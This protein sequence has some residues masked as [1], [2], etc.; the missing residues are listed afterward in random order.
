MTRNIAIT[1]TKTATKIPIIM[2]K[3]FSTNV[4]SS[5]SD[6]LA[7]ALAAGDDSAFEDDFTKLVQK[8]A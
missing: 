3:F 1:V 6:V 5:C 7:E 4:G 2:P 8:R